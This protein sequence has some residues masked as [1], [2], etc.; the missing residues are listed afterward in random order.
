MAYPNIQ[1]IQALRETA[2]NLKNGSTYAWGNHGS[3][4]CGNLLQVVT[5]LSKEEILAHAHQG[6]GEWTELS[7]E[8]CGVT[9]A[10]IDLLVKKLQ[11]I[12]LTPSDIHG[13]E[14][15]DNRK[16]LEQLPS[17]FRWLK[18]NDRSDV[19]DYF[20]TFATMLE[21]ELIDKV[22]ISSLLNYAILQKV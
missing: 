2:N 6:I 8:Y 1:L 9:N 18:K 4:N 3:C 11:D 10:P 16:I 14:Y 15:L 17:G 21:N 20:E 12:G 19:I 5:N 7:A 22:D 13:L